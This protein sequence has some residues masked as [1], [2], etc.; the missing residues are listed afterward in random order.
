M[1]AGQEQERE[2]EEK[3][4]KE[5]G[6]LEGRQVTSTKPTTDQALKPLE[7]ICTYVHIR[8]SLYARSIQVDLEK[9]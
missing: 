6:K 7:K 3:G 2:E 1:G 5:K 8:T 9:D 4:R